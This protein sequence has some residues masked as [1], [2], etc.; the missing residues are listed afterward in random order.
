MAS[1][2]ADTSGRLL[3]KL[4]GP[5]AEKKRLFAALGASCDAFCCA[6]TGRGA[7]GAKASRGIGTAGRVA[8]LNLLLP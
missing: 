6:G 7:G 4:D 2:S 1:T 8:P 3:E 5:A